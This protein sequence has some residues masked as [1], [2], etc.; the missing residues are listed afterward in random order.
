[1]KRKKVLPSRKGGMAKIVRAVLIILGLAVVFLTRPSLLDAQP[2]IERTDIFFIPSVEHVQMSPEQQIIK[3][4][5]KEFGNKSDIALAV[6]YAESH[7]VVDAKG[8]LNNKQAPE[9]SHCYAQINV[10]K[11]KDKIAGR[12]INDIEVCADVAKKVYDERKLFGENGFNAWTRY[13]D[14]TYEKYVDN[15]VDK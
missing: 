6:F 7:F 12:N 14:G 15:F 13:T 8:D 4:V 5:R 9:G 10:A 2:K 1:M 3:A 11:H